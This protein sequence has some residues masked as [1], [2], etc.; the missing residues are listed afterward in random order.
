[1]RLVIML[2]ALL[3]IGGCAST[4]KSHFEQIGARVVGEPTPTCEAG[5]ESALSNGSVTI[6]PGETICIALE[7]RGDAV[8]PSRVVSTANPENTLVLR[9]WQEPGKDEMVLTL[10]NPLHTFLRYQAVMLRP[11]S[12]RV[13]YTSSC[14]VLSRRIGMEYWPHKISELTLSNFEQLPDSKTIECR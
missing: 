14:P 10:H 2:L 13:E 3:L 9:F 4:P 11:G 6:R 12:S 7:L 5:H 8:I 1:M